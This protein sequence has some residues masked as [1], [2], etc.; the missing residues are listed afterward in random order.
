MS[1]KQLVQI[2]YQLARIWYNLVLHLLQFDQ[3]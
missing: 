2:Y 1:A 3:M